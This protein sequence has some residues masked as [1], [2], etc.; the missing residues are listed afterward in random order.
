MMK[1]SIYTGLD[2]NPTYAAELEAHCQ[3]RT[4]EM[5]DAKEGISALLEKRKPI[6]QGR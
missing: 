3:S 5:E 1:R 2:W 4:F 6:F